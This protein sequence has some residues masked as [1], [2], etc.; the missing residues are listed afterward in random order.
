MLA[1]DRRLE[2]WLAGHRIGALNPFFEGLTY[3]GDMGLLWLVLAA[4][5]ALVT[6]RWQPL[7]W[8]AAADLVAQVSTA[9]IRS[10]VG[11]HRPYVHTLVAEPHSGS[12]PSGHAAASF[13]CAVVLASFVPRYRVALLV[14]AALIAV[15][16]T[17]VGVHYPLDV[18]AGAAWGT[19][20]GAGLLE[21]RG[22]AARRASG[23]RATG[24]R[25]SSSGSRERP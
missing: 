25:R 23:R 14:I 18:L 24:G 21:L 20:I 10:A 7:A 17:Y 3:A 8:V 12:F 15:S 9:L 6:R 2:S 4:V 16:R 13:A 22:G 19:L 1:W 5:V 11:R